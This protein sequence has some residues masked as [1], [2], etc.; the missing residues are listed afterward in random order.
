MSAVPSRPDRGRPA[1]VEAI[2]ITLDRVSKRFGAQTVLSRLSLEVPAGQFLAIVGRS[3]SGKSTLLRLLCGLEQPDAGSI[4]FDGGPARPG[5][6]RI[7]FQEPRLLPWATLEENVTVGLG[8]GPSRQHGRALALAALRS[9]GLESRAGDWPEKLSGGQKQRVAL[10]RALVSRPGLLLLDEPLGALD[11]LTR[12]EMQDLVSE[13]W[14]A[15]RATA[16][17]V[18]HDVGEAVRLA[19]RVLLLENGAVTLDLP[20][21]APHP[22]PQR[23]PAAADLEAC[24]LQRLMVG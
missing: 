17:L 7:M 8:R 6:A 5:M 23:S 1:G 22:R 21:A 19:D 20:H 3:G 13:A 10:A 11:A 4:L 16:V 14:R 2:A 9:V 15:E 12:L 18:T 24:I